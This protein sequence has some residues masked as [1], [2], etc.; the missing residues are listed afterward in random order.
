MRGGQS[1][2]CAC[3]GRWQFSLPLRLTTA[4]NWRTS[5]FHSKNNTSATRALDSLLLAE[6]KKPG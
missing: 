6:C 4:L 5:M 1:C 2:S 3:G